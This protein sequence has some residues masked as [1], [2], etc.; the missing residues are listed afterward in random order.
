[1]SGRNGA[2]GVVAVCE[3]RWRRS[4]SPPPAPGPGRLLAGLLAAAAAPPPPRPLRSRLQEAEAGAEEATR[5]VSASRQ[6]S[7]Q[8]HG[9]ELEQCCMPHGSRPCAAPSPSRRPAAV[10][11]REQRVSD[12]RQRKAAR[13]RYQ[14]VLTSWGPTHAY[15]AFSKKL[16]P[17]PVPGP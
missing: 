14:P 3:W 9:V 16:K 12:V 1:A 6:V 13:S 11:Q 5:L 8:E 10:E 4:C 17:R 2:S 15:C 7:R